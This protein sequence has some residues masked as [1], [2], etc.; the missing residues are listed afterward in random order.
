MKLENA[1][2]KVLKKPFDFRTRTD[3]YIQLPDGQTFDYYN[4]MHEIPT[5]CYDGEQI[6]IGEQAIPTGEP[7][8][9][10][11]RAE[12]TASSCGTIWDGDNPVAGLDG[13]TLI[14][15]GIIAVI[16]FLVKLVAIFIVLYVLM[17][18]WLHP[19][20]PIATEQVMVD[21]CYKIITY[22]D[23]ST[24]T[25]DSCDPAGPTVKNRTDPPG[26][27]WE[28]L[29][30]WAAIGAVVIGGVFVVSSLIKTRERAQYGIPPPTYKA[31]PSK[32]KE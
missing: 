4:Y 14:A 5:T 25:V 10:N 22:P 11:E 21:G 19:C 32:Q 27:N 2:I 23:C 20:G 31:P 12:C 26:P 15:P 28:E 6:S 24:L 3:T 17:S 1:G 7:I 16:I 13:Q 18:K 8:I 9:C 30:K 29:I